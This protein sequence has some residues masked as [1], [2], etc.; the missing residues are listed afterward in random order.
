MSKKVTVPVSDTCKLEKYSGSSG[1]YVSYG[2]LRSVSNFAYTS[3]KD[4]IKELQDLQKE[5]EEEYED[6]ALRESR[7]CGC[8]GSCDCNPSLILYGTREEN[9]LERKVRLERAKED[10][11]RQEKSDKAEYERLQKKFD[12]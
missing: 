4:A 9:E 5:H 11:A 7:N 2:Y 12:S 8:Y 1:E 6:L 3:L 10:K